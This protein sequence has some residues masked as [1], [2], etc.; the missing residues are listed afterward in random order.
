MSIYRE[1]DR[2][3]RSCRRACYSV[4]RAV[5]HPALTVAAVAFVLPDHSGNRA[6][7]LSLVPCSNSQPLIGPGDRRIWHN[8]ALILRRNGAVSLRGVLRIAVGSELCFSLLEPDSR[9]DPD[10]GNLSAHRALTD[11]QM[12]VM[13]FWL[14]PRLLNA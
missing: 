9:A 11:A 10:Y 8:F 14:T 7:W 12:L 1:S 5:W 13:F 2:V 4:F 6:P 3:R